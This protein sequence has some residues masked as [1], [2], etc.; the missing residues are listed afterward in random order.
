MTQKLKAFVINGL[1]RLHSRWL[2]RNI[3]KDAAK[4]ILPFSNVKEKDK[5]RNAYVCA[6]CKK[7]FRNS[8]IHIDHIEP[9]VDPNTGFTTFDIYIESLFVGVDGY[10]VLCIECHQ[11]KSAEENKT[12]VV[13]RRK[14]NAK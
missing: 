3:A 6:H 10:Q 2:P 1:R 7:V 12:R 5:S 4:T 14:K 9:V 13:T 11:V 8:E